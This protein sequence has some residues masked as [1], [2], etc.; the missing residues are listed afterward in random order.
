MALVRRTTVR[1]RNRSNSSTDTAGRAAK[2]SSDPSDDGLLKHS[3]R[4]KTT[5]LDYETMEQPQV[6]DKIF[7]SERT[8]QM[9]GGL[10]SI[11]NNYQGMLSGLLDPQHT[12][13]DAQWNHR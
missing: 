9:Y 12:V 10:G 2:D 6:S 4:E 1:N 11:I 8:A 3:A 5:F 7:T 13:D